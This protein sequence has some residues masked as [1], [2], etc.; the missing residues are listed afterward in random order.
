L[1]FYEVQYFNKLVLSAGQ[2][3]NI[4]NERDV[5][6][7][8]RNGTGTIDNSD[9]KSENTMPINSQILKARFIDCFQKANNKKT[10]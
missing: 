5:S 10:N 8:Q 9:Q 3:V 2:G 4:Q 6:S 1:I 7:Q